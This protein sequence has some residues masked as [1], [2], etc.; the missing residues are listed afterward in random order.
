MGA[1]FR[2]RWVKRSVDADRE[3]FGK[4]NPAFF[5]DLSVAGHIQAGQ[6]RAHLQEVD[7]KSMVGGGY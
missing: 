2:S 6:A 7:R 5:S 3:C 1:H 4:I